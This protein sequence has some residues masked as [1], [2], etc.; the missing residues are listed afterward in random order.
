M[1]DG[2]VKEFT[3]TNGDKFLNPGFPVPTGLTNQQ[4]STIGYTD[5]T[6]ELQPTDIFSG[7]FLQD[8]RKVKFE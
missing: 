2:S 6:I 3:D 5:G 7:V 4:Y 1:A 8:L